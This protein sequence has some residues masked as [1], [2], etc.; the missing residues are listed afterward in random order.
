MCP[1]SDYFFPPQPSDVETD[2]E[3]YET[4]NDTEADLEFEEQ[5]GTVMLKES[6]DLQVS[7]PAPWL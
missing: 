1:F 2:S 3:E 4:Q 7:V 6:L 5:D